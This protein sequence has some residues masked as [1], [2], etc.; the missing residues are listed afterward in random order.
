M[1]AHAV[2][3]V[4][5]TER[6]SVSD[7]FLFSVTVAIDSSPSHIRS[8]SFLFANYEHGARIENLGSA[9]GRNWL[10]GGVSVV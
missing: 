2:V 8:A 4:L 7:R 1:L 10:S 5:E 6:G 3:W 9:L